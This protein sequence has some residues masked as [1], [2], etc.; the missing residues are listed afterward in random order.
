MPSRRSV[1]AAPEP[2]MPT[3]WRLAAARARLVDPDQVVDGVSGR[4]TA[5]IADRL[6]IAKGRRFTRHLSDL[7]A[8]AAEHGWEV[9]EDPEDR[10][11]V[12]LALGVRTVTVSGPPTGE[13][14]DAWLLLQYL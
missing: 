11:T 13:Q 5:Y 2:R 1:P 14:P 4:P 7:R 3:H 6:M 12:G 10:R 9:T 8:V